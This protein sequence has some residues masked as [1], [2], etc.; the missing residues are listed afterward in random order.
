[1]TTFIQHLHSYWAYLVVIALFIASINPIIG[2]I[3]KREYKPKDFRIALITLII[4]HTQFLIGL[5][6]FFVSPMN[7]W[8]SDTPVK[9]IMKDPTLRLYNVEHPITMILAIGALTVGYS[10]HKK[11][12]ISNAKLKSLAIGYSIA[13]LLVLSRIPWSNWLD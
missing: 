2:L 11:K 1:M 5:V 8:F 12:R 7:Q 9:E 3:Q 6:L 10:K 13:F 4:T